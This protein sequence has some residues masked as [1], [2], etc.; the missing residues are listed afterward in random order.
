MIIVCTAGHQRPKTHIFYL[1][2]IAA[3]MEQTIVRPRPEPVWIKRRI[4]I[5][6]GFQTSKP[7][8]A[9]HLLSLSLSTFEER[10][11]RLW[12]IVLHDFASA[13]CFFF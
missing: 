10:C 5:F 12:R 1:K 2:K 6:E 3:I 11:R 8:R 9:L 13:I 4:N 7:G